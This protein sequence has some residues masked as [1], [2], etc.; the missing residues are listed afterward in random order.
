MNWTIKLFIAMMLT[1]ATGMIIFTIWYWIG[2]FLEK[3]GYIQY[4][5]FA[6]TAGVDILVCSNG[7]SDDIY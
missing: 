7:I 1:S 2:R 4:H 5:V 3:M 6:I